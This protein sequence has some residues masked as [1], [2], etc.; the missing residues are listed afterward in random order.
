MGLALSCALML[1]LGVFMSPATAAQAA[2]AT[3][4]S[5]TRVYTGTDPFDGEDSRGQDTGPDNDR[6][7][8]QDSIGYSVEAGINNPGSQGGQTKYQHLTVTFDPLPLGFRWQGLPGGC[9]TSE[10]FRSALTGDGR[11]EPSVLTCDLGHRES[12]STYGFTP[13]LSVL[14]TVAEGTSVAPT[15]RVTAE[16]VAETTKLEAP[17]TLVT[18]APALLDVAIH[19]PSGAWDARSEVIVGNDGVAREGYSV[20]FPVDVKYVGRGSAS[21][22]GPITFDIR[23]PQLASPDTTIISV[24]DGTRGMASVPGRSGGSE[25]KANA[26]QESG[27]CSYTRD[28]N[29]PSIVH[30]TLTGTE[31]S[32]DFFPTHTAGGT[33]LKTVDADSSKKNAA[34]QYIASAGIRIHVPYTLFTNSKATVTAEVSNLSAS[35]LERSSEWDPGQGKTAAQMKTTTCE[36]LAGPVFCANTQNVVSVDLVRPAASTFSVPAK[37]DRVLNSRK[38]PE[39]TGDL[40]AK[41][42]YSDKQFTAENPEALPGS[43]YVGRGAVANYIPLGKIDN[44]LVLCQAID[45][46]YTTPVP[47]STTDPDRAAAVSVQTSSENK[48][49]QVLQQLSSYVKIQYGVGGNGGVNA[50]DGTGWSDDNPQAD[51]TC[52]DNDSTKWYDSINAPEAGPGAIT[53]IRA[54]VEGPTPEF[55]ATGWLS[56]GLDVALQIRPDAPISKLDGPVADQVRVETTNRQGVWEDDVLRP[57]SR[58]AATLLITEIPL[59]VTKTLANTAKTQYEAQE[60]ITW[61]I[62]AL[63]V[64]TGLSVPVR[65]VQ[66]TDTLPDELAYYPGSSKVGG[67]AVGDPT[68]G[69]DAAGKTTLH[70]NLGEMK[71]GD[72]RTLE[73]ETTTSPDVF[74][75]TQVENN[76]LATADGAL[77]ATSKASATITNSALFAVAKRSAPPVVQPGEEVRFDV[78]ITNLSTKEVPSSDFIDWLPFDGDGRAPK[79][80]FHGD[81]NLVSVS[82]KLGSQHTQ[83]LYTSYEQ[84]R[85]DLK[86]DLDP[87]AMSASIVWCE[88]TDFAKKPGCPSNMAEVTGL[89]FLG[90]NMAPGTSTTMRIVASLPQ[91]KAGDVLANTAGG[92]AGG[93]TT[94]LLSNVTVTN[95]VES[96]VS[97][98]AWQDSDRDGLLAEGESRLGG[99]VAVLQNADGNE[100]A[101]T[102]TN[103]KGEYTFKGILAGEYTV[104][105]EA[106]SH[107]LPTLQQA[108]T[109]SSV[110]SLIDATFTAR[111]SVPLGTDV[112]NINAGFIEQVDLQ[113]KGTQA[114]S[115]TI[116]QQAS[117]TFEVSNE[118]SSDIHEPVVIFTIPEGLSDA[119]VSAPKGWTIVDNGDGTWTATG[120]K[121]FAGGEKVEFDITGTVKSVEQLTFTAAGSASNDYEPNLDNNA[122][123]LSTTPKEPAT[124]SGSVFD[125]HNADGI[126][127]DTERVVEGLTVT[128]RDS[129]GHVVASTV[130]D[131]TGGFR[132]PNLPAGDYTAELE[133]P[134]GSTISTPGGATWSVTVAA[135][136]TA[137]HDFGLVK[138]VDL[139]VEGVSVT[140]GTIGQEVSAVFS[141]SNAGKENDISTPHVVFTI[142]ESVTNPVVSAPKGWTVTKNDD[143]T[144]TAVGPETFAPGTAVEITITGT[145]TTAEALVF[146]A[147]GSTPKDT[148]LNLANNSAELTAVLV[149]PAAITGLIFNDINENGIRDAGEKPF[150]AVEVKLHGPDGKILDSVLTDADGAFAFRQLPASD[151]EVSFETPEPYHLTTGSSIWDVHLAPGDA[152][153]NEFGLVKGEKP[154][155]PGAHPGEKPTTDTS[156]KAPSTPSPSAEGATLATTGADFGPAATLTILALLTGAGAMMAARLRT[157]ARRDS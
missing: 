55:L 60:R 5:I 46:R 152:A 119:K 19:A 4:G 151:Y 91:G 145:V 25:T 67:V 69:V 108:G 49:D 64:S 148:E 85:I 62:K 117:A 23:I 40:T 10:D 126:W 88:A 102:T 35:A 30:M 34:L 36:T 127:Q 22:E 147:E 65:N 141:I 45:N 80:S 33:A 139:Q 94:N 41:A 26:V 133:Q 132:F 28:V 95:V 111:A 157:R 66:M 56:L 2:E 89:R 71:L 129:D 149:I 31:T 93:F 74:Q 53:K 11:T 140:V 112:R 78:R 51:F 72:S 143:G 43:K 124:I 142:P 105:F 100:V 114:S 20:S 146:T 3:T 6:V 59:R 128:L 63:T 15:A 57:K 87:Q 50:G 96:S 1:L 61:R 79:S 18:A 27:T 44:R 101:R 83:T 115:G 130:V 125:D 109:D 138:E 118:L 120:P 73:Y 48:P 131:S 134:K 84:S 135:G 122:A 113:V 82:Q 153:N 42:F 123:T 76:V 54:V 75:G 121:T 154:A 116:G 81:L 110:W 137:T 29:D 16:G 92:R 77:P 103:T 58:S 14:G 155:Q 136:E 37:S 90:D 144:W 150:S 39:T 98:T 156:E 9:L 12:G 86:K 21:V 106:G 8:V 13:V 104:R 99:V 24:C 107:E 68:I 97:G 32:P 38:N 47:F 17:A 52:G 7:R 70:W